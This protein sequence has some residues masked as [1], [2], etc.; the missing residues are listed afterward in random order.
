MNLNNEMSASIRIGRGVKQSNAFSAII[1][2]CV[3]DWIL[4]ELD[5][6]IGVSIRPCIRVNY[7]AFPDDVVLMAES[8]AGLNRLV[9]SYEKDLSKGGLKPNPGKFAT[10]SMW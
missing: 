1:F 6:N 7:L 5:E 9:A 3:M 10:I 8:V 2:N 4:S